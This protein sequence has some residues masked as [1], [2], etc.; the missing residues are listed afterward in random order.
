M[1][2]Y[3][4]LSLLKEESIE[5]KANESNMDLFNEIFRSLPVSEQNQVVVAPQSPSSEASTQRGYRQSAP[6]LQVYYKLYPE[7]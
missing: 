6:D 1:S 2:K 5:E 7:I 4:I 3:P